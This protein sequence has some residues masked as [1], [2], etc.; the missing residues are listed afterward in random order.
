DDQAFA[1]TDADFHL[2]S[3]NVRRS[4][5]RNTPSAIN[6]VFSFRQFW[7]GRA[8]NDFNGVNPFGNRDADARVGH[9]GAAGGIE[10]VAISLTNSS[11]ASQA[12]GPPGNGVE[13]SAEGRTLSDIGRKLLSVRPLGA[14]QVSRS[15]S[16][17][18]DLAH[19]SGRGLSASYGDMIKQA[20][21]SDWWNSG[22][23]VTG[24]S[25]RSYSLMQFNFPLFWGLAIQA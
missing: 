15:D 21:Q 22:E 24:A 11:L 14:Q 25:G 13:M 12:T 10:K 20:F 2:G 1:S 3:V 18:G 23:A 17:L 7:D 16:M 9:V 5:G 19:G 8:Q 6:A 4:T